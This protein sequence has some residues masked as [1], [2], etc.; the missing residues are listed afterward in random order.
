MAKK[1]KKNNKKNN[2]KEANKPFDFPLLIV[3]LILLGMR[4]YNGAFSKFTIITCNNR[5]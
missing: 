4:N 3:V 1:V 5:K 2:K